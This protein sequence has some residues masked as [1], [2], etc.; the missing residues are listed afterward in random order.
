MAPARFARSSQLSGWA[1][2]D[3]PKARCTNAHSEC[4]RGAAWRCFSPSLLPLGI[5]VGDVDAGEDEDGPI[6]ERVRA[7]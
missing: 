3:S 7:S 5:P 1:G 2:A 4:A 6:A